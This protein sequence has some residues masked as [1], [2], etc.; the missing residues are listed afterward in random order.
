MIDR[1]H[2]FVNFQG[3]VG[4]IATSAGAPVTYT[5]VSNT[6]NTALIYNN[7]FMDTM[8]HIHRE[9][10]PERINHGGGTGAFG[11]FQVTHDISHICKADFLNKVG[12]KTP[13]AVRFSPSLS[14]KGSSEL[15]RDARGFSV[16][17]YTKEGNF[18]IAGCNAP[19][20]FYKDPL[21]FVTFMHAQKRNPATN[22][23][24]RDAV[25]DTLTLFPE[26]L[27]AF[28]RSFSDTGIPANYRYMPGFGIHTFQVE[29]KTGHYN[30]V[31][32][33]IIP[34]AGIKNLM[35]EEARNI[36]A[37]DPHYFT[38]DLYRAIGTSNFP[39]WRVSV[40][41]LTETDV[42]RDGP[43]VFDAT[44]LLPLKK[45]PLHQVG[46]L[47]LNRNAKNNFAE[48]EQLAFSP[49]NIVPGILGSPDKLY[50]ARVFAYRDTQN[51][52]L[53]KNFNRIPVNCPFQVRTFTYNRDGRPPVADNEED[54]P[55][56]YP[57]SFHGPV[58]YMTKSRSGLIN[59]V[60][61]KADN[62]D[63][64]R[65]FYVNELTHDEKSRVIENIVFS[66]Q[67]VSFASLQKKAIDILSTIHPD[68]GD[69][70]AQR[71]NVTM[72]N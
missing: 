10:I 64:T 67:D 72:C 56:Y 52:R 2:G 40:Q 37:E 19:V 9:R 48:I 8:S 61:G 27:H 15:N 44:R 17:F 6:L 34:C 68:L 54:I 22:L 47:I 18:D 7:Y 36:S 24:S 4:G 53:G 41:I 33:H 11:Y 32:F 30:F 59:I 43:K 29:N 49:G 5:E 58:P 55:N 46:R 16:K 66:L 60:E 65:D 1:N 51:Y 70:V 63:Q 13:V 26:S 45:Y 20:Y 69:R 39:C 21:L 35:T 71:L 23:F 62:F 50:E 31:R 28:L 3:P 57:N 42:K 14:E 38:R 12:K 25:W